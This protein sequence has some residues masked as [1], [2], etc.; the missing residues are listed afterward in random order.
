MKTYSMK[1]KSCGGILDLSQDREI[2]FCP[3]CGSRELIEVSDEVR[4]ERIR[5]ETKRGIEKDKGENR[6]GMLADLYEARQKRRQQK[7]DEKQKEREDE[8]RQYPYIT[9]MMLAVV[10]LCWLLVK[11]LHS[12]L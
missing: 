3:Y 4:K 1:C 10:F 6:R 12:L 8:S 2:L 5:S 9:I 11:S 7:I